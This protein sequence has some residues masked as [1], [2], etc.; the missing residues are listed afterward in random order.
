MVDGLHVLC[1]FIS[2]NLRISGYI[3]IINSKGDKEA[4]WEIPFLM[5]W[6][7]AKL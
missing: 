5:T 4:P 3:T 2:Y 7:K 1:R 6:K